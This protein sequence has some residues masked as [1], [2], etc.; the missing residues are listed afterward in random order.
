LHGAMVAEQS[1]DAEGELLRRIRAEFGDGIPVS[2]SLDWHANVSEAMVRHATYLT[3]YRRYPHVDMA[4]TGERAYQKLREMILGEPRP[5]AAF[6]QLP[7]LIPLCIQNDDR[8]VMRDLLAAMRAAE[9][10]WGVDVSFFP[11]FPASDFAD[12]GPSLVVYGSDSRVAETVASRL[13]EQVLAAEPALQEPLLDVE[14]AVRYA[15]QASQQASKPIVIADTQDN[16]GAGGTSDT[17]GIIRELVRQQARNAVVGLVYDPDAAALAH[18]AGQGRTLTLSLGGRSQAAGDSPLTADYLVEYVSDGQVRC[19]G[20]FRKGLSMDL[21]RSCLLRLGDVQIAVC[22]EQSQLAD[23]EQLRY[24]SVEPGEKKIICVK[25]SA[26]FR[27]AF[28]PI[29]SEII[30]GLAPGLMV[31][32]PAELPWRRL[33]PGVRLSPLSTRTSQ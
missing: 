1:L 33:R 25:S 10:E 17:M 14:S 21:G 15:I 27:A 29:A 9:V 16:P 6:R 22:S 7:Y 5:V 24:L 11:G 3:G 30:I 18:A 8:P 32:D 12:C 31:S 26:H 23:L 20:D 28:Q 2:L 13:Y 19:S 4:A